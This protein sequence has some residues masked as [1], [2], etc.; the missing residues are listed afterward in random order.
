MRRRAIDCGVRRKQ[1]KSLTQ[2]RN[3]HLR[4]LRIDFFLEH[5][6]LLK[7]QHEF[8]RDEFALFGGRVHNDALEF[9]F[10]SNVP[11]PET[12]NDVSSSSASA[13][14][15]AIAVTSL[16]ASLGLTLASAANFAIKSLLFTSCNLKDGY[17]LSR[18]S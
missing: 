17:I 15:V 7:G 12:L 8:G 14:E 13:I 2:P 10:T 18:D 11:K 16:C 4:V 9:F 3:K 5:V 6:A 1:Q